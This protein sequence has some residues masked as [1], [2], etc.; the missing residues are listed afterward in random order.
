[1]KKNDNL[2]LMILSSMLSALM[3]VGAY[4]R[5]PVG[6]VPIVLTNMFAVLAGLLLGPVW[7]SASVGLYLLLGLIGLPVFSGGG[8]PAYFTGPTGGYL[9][10]YA[11]AAF[12]A[13]AAGQI[14]KRRN[15]KA[16]AYIVSASAVLCGFAVIYAA[17]IPWLKLILDLTWKQAAAAGLLPFL[18]GDAIK[19][20]AVFAISIS[21]RKTVPAFLP[22]GGG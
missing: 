10:G 8:G 3:I 21:I 6:P 9:L 20:G 19:A 5:I 12:A 2:K 15:G 11:A 7:G 16:G 22:G 14:G 18:P 13:G 4:I 1:M 17:G